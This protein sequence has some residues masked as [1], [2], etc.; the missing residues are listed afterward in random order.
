MD[1]VAISQNGFNE[2]ASDM[3]TYEELHEFMGM[4]QD[5][6]NEAFKTVK[7]DVYEYLSCSALKARADWDTSKRKPFVGKYPDCIGQGA[8][9]LIGPSG[10]NEGMNALMACYFLKHSDPV[11]MGI[12]GG[13]IHTTPPMY[14][15]C[16]RIGANLKPVIKRLRYGPV[17][18]FN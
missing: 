18:S 13:G 10:N 8:V 6:Y 9:Q 2:Y 5:S 17:F 1:L 3:I 11:C 16:W 7:C 4:C 14:T 12:N 15:L